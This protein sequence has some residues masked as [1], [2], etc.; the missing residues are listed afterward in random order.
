M[1]ES[2]S[3]ADLVQEVARHLYDVEERCV[4]THLARVDGHT[5]DEKSMLQMLP[6]KLASMRR[7][8]GLLK[9]HQL[10][11][12]VC[13]ASRVVAWAIDTSQF[14]QVVAHRARHALEHGPAD[15]RLAAI[16]R[17]AAA[18]HHA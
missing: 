7:A 1:S 12:D 16:L 5:A 13:G 3:F 11:N 2:S 18:F 6:L 9:Q 15:E 14:S 17:R 4:L 8:L 10:V